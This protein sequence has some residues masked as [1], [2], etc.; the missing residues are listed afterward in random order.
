MARAHAAPEASDTPAATPRHT[1]EEASA[2]L[3]SGL[4]L[5]RPRLAHGYGCP[6][7]SAGPCT[8]G[9]QEVVDGT[10]ELVDALEAARPPAP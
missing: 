8:C 1:L 5:M 7:E 6:S 10:E 3:L 2:L 9:Y 4:Q